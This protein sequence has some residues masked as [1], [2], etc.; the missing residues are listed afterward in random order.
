MK[1]LIQTV[2]KNKKHLKLLLLTIVMML[3]MTVANAL[4]IFAIGF[5]TKKGPAEGGGGFFERVTATFNSWVPIHDSPLYLAAFIVFV[6]LFKAICLFSHRFLARLTAI[7]IQ[8]DLR[9]QFFEHL[10]K[11]PMRFFQNHNMGSLSSRVVSD[12]SMVAEAI[13]ATIINYIQTPVGVALYLTI[14]ILTSWQLSL[15]IFLGFPL[16]LFPIWFLAKRVKRV[17]REIQK[18]QERFSSVLIDFIGGIQTVKAFAMEAFSFK[19][20][21]ELNDRMAFLER[22]SALYDL[23]TR[24]IVHSIAMLFL[25]ATL[26]V[27]LY[28]LNM[29]VSEVLIFC[30]ML[31]LFYE[32]IK[33]FAEENSHIQR[34]VSA[35]ERMEEVLHMPVE[36]PKEQGNQTF[37]TLHNEIRFS[38][39]WFRYNQEWILKDLNLSIKKRG[40]GRTRRS[41]RGRKIEPRAAIAPPLRL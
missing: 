17:S 29:N 26:I 11:M 37:R 15:L 6:A 38:N 1:F 10:Q 7:K 31:Y 21:E 36:K 8:Q 28:V 32:P 30:G 25:A 19:K 5:I 22:K 41:D 20:Y 12:A 35:A 23:S 39:V 4:E 24:P 40:D 9:L 16:L 3:F 33:K 34:G 13:N 27:G 14:C 2:F 18:N